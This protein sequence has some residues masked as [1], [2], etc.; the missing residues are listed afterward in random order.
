MYC[1]IADNPTACSSRMRIRRSGSGERS[2]SEN[3]DTV[4]L[5]METQAAGPRTEAPP[6]CSTSMPPVA[7][8]IVSHSQGSTSRRPG[9]SDAERPFSR[10]SICQAILTD[11]EPSEDLWSQWQR[12]VSV[13]DP[14]PL[15]VAELASRFERYFDAMKT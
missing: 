1:F 12:V 5:R 3:P 11:M 15:E 13:D 2:T 10:P 4:H 9:S 14:D 8:A 6:W 7:R